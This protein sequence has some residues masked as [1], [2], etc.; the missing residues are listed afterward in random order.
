MTPVR[1]VGQSTSLRGLDVK[2]TAAARAA[3]SVLIQ[4]ETGSGKEL[5]ARAI[6]ER[7]SRGDARFVPV[8]CGALPE[9]LAESEL[10]GYKRGAFTTAL[11]DKRGLFEEAHRGTLF[12]DEISNTTPRFQVK[13]LRVL[14][15]KQVRR[16]GDVVDRNFD[17]RILAATNGDLY[18]MASEGRFRLD[19]FYRLSVFLIRVPPL[20]E[21][22]GDVPLLVDHILEGLNAQ[23]GQSRR[24]SSEALGKLSG[25]EYPGNVRELQNL[26]ERA[27][28]MSPEDTI[29]P[30]VVLL[31]SEALR[32][33]ASGQT[34]ALE[35]APLQSPSGALPVGNFW[36]SIARPYANR[37]ITRRQVEAVIRRALEETGGNYRK[38]VE[39]F[40]MPRCDYKR[41][42]DFLRRHQ[43]N[44]DFRPYRQKTK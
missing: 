6:H 23:T 2:T 7:S 29:R 14:Q 24:M 8:D 27:Y 12:L 32:E 28:F 33:P 17:V 26:I 31:P 43:C 44:V 30:E 11:A 18:G 9:E 38:V 39:L 37:T 19:L 22:P 3:S 13:L 10:F 25:Y 16:L 41:F 42:M 34:S 1:L 15:D 21:R 36:D 20:R 5:V 4:G 40:N 35:F